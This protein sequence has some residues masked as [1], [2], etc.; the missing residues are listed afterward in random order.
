MALR[1]RCALDAL[2][3]VCEWLE[4]E[5]GE[6]AVSA[7][8]MTCYV[9]RYVCTLFC[10]FIYSVLLLLFLKEEKQV[11][12]D[13]YPFIMYFELLSSFISSFVCA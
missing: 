6:V 7:L 9:L 4:N 3:D 11:F 12:C 5:S 8:R 2:E 13:P 10:K 1:Q